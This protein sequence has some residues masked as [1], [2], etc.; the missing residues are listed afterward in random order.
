MK[1]DRGGWVALSV[2]KGLLN[3]VHGGAERNYCHFRAFQDIQGERA[4]SLD[5]WRESVRYWLALDSFS[6]LCSS[7]WS[8]SRAQG[9]GITGSDVQGNSGLQ[10]CF[11]APAHTPVAEHLASSN[12]PFPYAIKSEDRGSLPAAGEAE[13]GSMPYS[14]SGMHWGSHGS[15]S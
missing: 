5:P 9:P 2:S 3:T 11:T 4:V 10:T 7:G 12:A 8:S 14:V 15:C 13:K 1:W 6:V